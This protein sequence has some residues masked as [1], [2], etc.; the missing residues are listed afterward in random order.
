MNLLQESEEREV[1]NCD[2][3]GWKEEIEKQGEADTR[4]MDASQKK[5]RNALVLF[6]I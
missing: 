1:D 3:F 5:T 4:N 6:C 2:K